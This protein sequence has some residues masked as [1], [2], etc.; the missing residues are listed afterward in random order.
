VLD[1]AGFEA[2][3]SE[4]PGAKRTRKE[5]PLVPGGLEIDQPHSGKPCRAE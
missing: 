5:A 2:L 3:V 1:E 4:F